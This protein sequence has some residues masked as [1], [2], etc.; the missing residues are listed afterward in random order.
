MNTA[1]IKSLVSI[2]FGLSISEA[3]LFVA[4]TFSIILSRLAKEKSVGID[5]FGKFKSANGDIRFIPSGK[6]ERK[7]NMS[8]NNLETV[9]IEAETKVPFDQQEDEYGEISVL[10]KTEDVKEESAKSTDTS[11]RRLISEDVVK[12]H[13]EIIKKENTDDDT[14]NLWG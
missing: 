2:K 12:L 11:Q 5:S 7:V 9:T 13:N 3:D 1:D 6:L 14:F 8:F 4:N 10:N